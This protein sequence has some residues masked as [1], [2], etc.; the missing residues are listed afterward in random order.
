MVFRRRLLGKIIGM[1]ADGRRKCVW[2]VEDGTET[3]FERVV[4]RE[5][6][7]EGNSGLMV[8][9]DFVDLFR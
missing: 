5:T 8:F 4:M 2:V 3:G 9:L 1:F 6:Y 7:F